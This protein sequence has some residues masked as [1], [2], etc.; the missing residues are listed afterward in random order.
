MPYWSGL[1]SVTPRDRIVSWN[2]YD[3]VVEM[4]EQLLKTA[5]KKA[6]VWQ[7]ID[8]G[9]RC[10][11]ARGGMPMSPHS[12]CYGT[13]IVGGYVQ[14]NRREV[15]VYRSSDSEVKVWDMFNNVVQ[16]L[17]ISGGSVESDWIDGRGGVLV[18]DFLGYN[19][20]KR[21]SAEVLISVDGVNWVNLENENVIFPVDRFKVKLNNITSQFEVLRLRI[22]KEKENWWYFAEN[23]PLRM[24][25]LFRWGI[26]VQPF[27]VRVWTI[28]DEKKG[29]VFRTGDLIL[30]LEGYYAGYRYS[31][32]NN[33]VTQFV[34]E[35]D[36]GIDSDSS[37]ILTQVLGMRKVK[38]AEQ[39]YRVW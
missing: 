12:I 26:D 29:L 6:V 5:G 34:R 7:R 24:E 39:D 13:G 19:L 31:V 14:F 21:G 8:I 32:V 23:P 4:Q 38:S 11:C 37:G 28:I 30:W 10:P 27:D 18:A 35:R 33:R 20:Y 36:Y 22:S 16:V 25:Q 9:E 1:H 17:N 2:G 3:R 15:Y